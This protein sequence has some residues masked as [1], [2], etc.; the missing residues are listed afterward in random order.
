MIGTMTQG[1]LVVNLYYSVYYR[2]VDVNARQC[3]SSTPLRVVTLMISAG[4]LMR[5]G[6]V[7][8]RGLG[9]RLVSCAEGVLELERV[10]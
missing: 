10:R 3:T 4:M 6:V 7:V 1:H 5:C 2:R 8:G 9:D